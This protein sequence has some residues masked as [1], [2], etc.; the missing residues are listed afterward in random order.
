MCIDKYIYFVIF[1][2]DTRFCS[3]TLRIPQPFAICCEWNLWMAQNTF[4]NKP[5]ETRQGNILSEFSNDD[6][7]H[8]AIYYGPN[9][10][11]TLAFKVS[12]DVALVLLI[13]RIWTN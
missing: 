8:F 9:G 6:I 5:K 7:S 3:E 1:S 2:L 10:L 4:T 12:I 11:Q 13:P